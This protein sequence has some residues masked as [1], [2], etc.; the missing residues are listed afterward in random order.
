MT[1]DRPACPFDAPRAAHNEHWDFVARLE[2]SSLYLSAN[3]TYRGYCLLVFDP[4]HA[5][6]LDELNAEEWAAFSTDLYAAHHAIVQ[7]VR[8]VHMNVELLGN[9]VRHLHWHLV[10][11]NPGDERWGG[12]IWT[13]SLSEMKTTALPLQERQGLIQQIASG[14]EV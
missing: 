2:V 6:R 8:P 10:P 4:R 11:R 3:Q 5:T 7:A 12:P 1:S 9:V 14:L 13:S